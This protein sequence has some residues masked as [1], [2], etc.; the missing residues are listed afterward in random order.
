MSTR[1]THTDELRKLSRSEWAALPSDEPGELVD[2]ALVEEEMADYVHAFVVAWI[3][4]MVGGWAFPRDAWVAASDA[5]FGVSEDRGRK[6]DATVY[7]P[8]APR[9]PARGLVT[10]PPSI[11]IEVVSPTPRDARRDR[12]EKLGDYAGFGVAYY[13]IVDPQLRTFDV[14]ELGED[15]RYV[16]ALAVTGGQVEVPGCDGLTLDLDELWRRVD[17]L[18]A[19]DDAG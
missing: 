6:P 10:V 12:V 11:A 3:I 19:S 4:T 9:P 7:L 5:R 16:H 15:G 1:A 8:D 2:G 14:L 17:A 18:P 13:W